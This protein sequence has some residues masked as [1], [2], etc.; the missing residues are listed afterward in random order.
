MQEKQKMCLLR[1]F[2]YTW[3]AKSLTVLSLE[4]YFCRSPPLFLFHHPK[5]LCRFFLTF[6]LHFVVFFSVNE[7]QTVKTGSLTYRSVFTVCVQYERIRSKCRA[8][9]AAETSYYN[10]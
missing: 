7:E 2:L 9:D 3:R 1:A 4:H 10:P 6:T 8:C 5:S